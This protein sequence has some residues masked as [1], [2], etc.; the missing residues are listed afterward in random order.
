MTQTSGRVRIGIIGPG[1]W[2]ETMF[3]PALRAHP[4]AE[5]VAICGRDADRTRAFAEANGIPLVFTDPDTMYASGAIDAV[6]IST[7]NKTHHPLTMSALAHGI[8]VLCEKPLAMNP[9]E[10]DEMAARAAETGLTC[11]VPFTYRFMPTSQ[12][13]KRLIDEGYVGRPYLLNLRYY[14]GF[15]RGGEYAWRFD[16]AEAGSGVLGD[17]GSHWLDMARWL[18]GDVVAVTCTLTHHVARGPRPDGR[19]YE[20]GDDGANILVE[21]ANGAHGVIVVSAVCYE[22]S[23]FGQTHEFDVHGSEGTVYAVNDWNQLQQVRGARDGEHIHD[24][25]IPDDIWGGVRRDVVHDTYRD[26]FRSTD[27]LAR[28]WVSAIRDGRPR[29]EPTFDDGAA[30]QHLVA[31]CQRSAAE[32]RRVLLAE[33]GG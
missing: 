10:A 13:V 9:V 27:V 17:L 31:A 22:D 15:A 24:L 6:V 16:L 26:I 14:T 33:F 8:H 25:P 11:L 29:V 4:D 18:L 30:V 2:S 28:G 21:F 32:G 12:Y 5:L 3:V 19:P 20:Q 1:W 23:P 7:V